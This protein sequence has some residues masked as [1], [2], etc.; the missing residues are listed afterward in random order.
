[1]VEVRKVTAA[2]VPA[3]AEAL[4]RSFFDDPVMTYI[5]PARNQARRLRRFFEIELRHM[6]LPLDETYTTAGPIMGAAVWS[7]PGRWRPPAS[8]LIRSGPAFLRAIGGRLRAAVNL[9]GVVERKHPKEPHYYLST[10]G[11]EPDAQRK[12][13]G[14]ALLRPVLDRCDEE[15][16]PA[17]LESSKE[18][19]VPYYRRHGFEVTEE[20]TV[21]GGPTLWLMWREPQPAGWGGKAPSSTTR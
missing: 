1:M 20:V 19:N 13:V 2:D 7:P 12:G 18:V 3:V 8:V 14:S 9:M 16:L 17:Y 10:L 5:I 15:G 6:A 4:T 21:P 11:T